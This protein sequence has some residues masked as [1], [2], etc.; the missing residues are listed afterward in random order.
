VVLRP[1]LAA[2]YIEQFHEAPP[3]LFADLMKTS[4]KEL[5]N[6]I[7]YFDMIPAEVFAPMEDSFGKGG[8]KNFNGIMTDLQ[9]QTC[10][11]G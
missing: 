7:A 9:M 11:E 10:L 3:V 4:F 2:I 6:I 1:L 8:E 5:F